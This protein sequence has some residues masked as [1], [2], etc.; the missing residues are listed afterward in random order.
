MHGI[1]QARVLEWVPNTFFRITRLS[2]RLRWVHADEEGKEL[3]QRSCRSWSAWTFRSQE[4]RLEI[5]LRRLKHKNAKKKKKKSLE[6]YQLESKYRVNTLEK[7]PGDVAD[8]QIV[9]LLDAWKRRS[10]H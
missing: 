8:M 3:L 6:F 10:P 9:W 4:T 1:L 2:H 5:E 7:T